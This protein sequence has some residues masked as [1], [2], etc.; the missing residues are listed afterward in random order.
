MFTA[1]DL[2]ELKNGMNARVKELEKI[3]QS[4]KTTSKT[5]DIIGRKLIVADALTEK[6][7]KHL[8]ELENVWINLN[9]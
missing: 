7:E 4:C 6:I 5:M 8:K 3:L 1:K 9:L 2:I